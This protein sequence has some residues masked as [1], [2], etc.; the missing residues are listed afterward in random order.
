MWQTLRQRFRTALRY[1]LIAL[2]LL[3]LL[4]AVAVSMVFALYWLMGFSRDT[5]LSVA[6]GDYA[7]AQRAM[8]EWQDGYQV[9]LQQ[10]AG[11][12]K[13]RTALA[14]G[15]AAAV[16]GALAHV[17][18]DNGFFFLHVT[19]VAGNWL[20]EA[21][22]GG[23]GSS[24]PSPLTDRAARGRPGTALEVFSARNAAREGYLL[25][26][27][28]G[29][30]KSEDEARAV[31]LRVVQPVVDAQGRIVWVLDGAVLLNHNRE[32]LGFIQDRVFGSAA[33]FVRGAP[34]IALLLDNQR[35]AVSDSDIG[36]N[37]GTALSPEL[38]RQLRD[39]RDV[40][41]GRDNTGV[42]PLVSA[43]GPLYDVNGQPIGHLQVGFG[44][45]QFE[46][47]Q[48]GAAALFLL[49]FFAAAS[50]AGWIAV[51]GVR[52]VFQ[53]IEHM[54]AVVRA[55]ESGADQRIG[56]IGTADELGE[57]ARQ[58]D[59]MLDTLQE[60]NRALE[61][62]A[63]QLE[64]KVKER[65]HELGQ[66]NA[67]LEQTIRLLRQ[68]REQ[69]VMAEKLSALGQMAAGI[70][71]EINNPTAVIVGNLDVITNELGAAARPVAQ[72]IDL[73]HQQVERIR[74]IITGLTQ[75]ARSGPATGDIEEVDVN[76]LVKDVL[77]LVEHS[78]RPRAIAVSTQLQ[79]TRRAQIN[80]FDL[81]QV[82]INLIVNSG[83]AVDEGGRIAIRTRD[84][85]PHGVVISVQDNG[86]GIAPEQRKRLFDPFFTGDPRRGVGL[87]L[88]V[89]YGLVHRYG[90]RIS[91]HSRVG[92]GST[93]HVWLPRRPP[94]NAIQSNPSE[95]EVKRDHHY[96]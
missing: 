27:R 4:L 72:E 55:S 3:P 85:Q 91:V 13:F 66:K 94:T 54:T 49:L 78:L 19:G 52:S 61:R 14:R 47:D 36:Q 39:R 24:K 69:L 35:V 77:P 17:R 87:G 93:F 59:A 62:A 56:P 9:L 76:W 86:V 71:H 82:L 30:G 83:N 44:V 11:D 43:I 29:P 42:A 10:L 51:R 25:E 8:Q 75:F 12:A 46:R 5:L 15:D 38:A 40:W 23:A 89:S 50:V 81:E 41:V 96:V 73:I 34:V 80:V 90:G 65:T 58:F 53:P 6:R 37:A 95:P 45:A 84:A 20:F 32:L 68:T 48:L 70:A 60:R 28:L 1:K 79:A 92:K 88:S 64:D 7:L 21:R 26:S 57:L 16:R 67:E 33:A 18:E 2:V 74:H 63:H 31:V 22:R